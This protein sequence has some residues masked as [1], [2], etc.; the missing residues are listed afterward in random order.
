MKRNYQNLSDEEVFMLLYSDLKIQR[1]AFE[2]L[3][4]RY[5]TKVY[6]YCKRILFNDEVAED[7]F[8]ETFMKLYE[9]TKV[10]RE[11][12]NFSAY[13]FRIARNLCINEKH[14]KYNSF[15]P[16]EDFAFPADDPN[17][18]SKE[19]LDLLE[20][21]ME[22]L[23][24]KYKE[25]L[26]LKEYLGFSYQEIADLLDSTLPSVRINIYRAK[27]KVRELLSPYLHDYRNEKEK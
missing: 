17:S 11:M 2:E 5:A 3:Y 26:V 22:S 25:V 12:T 18:D 8:Q 10:K 20:T 6:T 13:I 7:V 9:S 15:V 1:L 14:K 27:N 4:A 23:P 21:A 16:L 19:K 24:K